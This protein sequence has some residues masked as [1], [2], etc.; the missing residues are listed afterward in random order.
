MAISVSQRISLIKGIAQ[1]LED[2]EWPM[3]DLTLTQFKLPT[4]NDFIGNKTTYVIQMVKVASD[5]ILIELAAHLGLIV[6]PTGRT[7]IDPTFW[8]T[9][10]FKL[11][12]SHLAEHRRWVGELQSELLKFGIS[13]FVAHNDIEPS[14]EWQTQIELALATCD[15]LVALLHKKFHESKWTD[16]EIG[17]VMG[18]SLPIFA[19]R[20]GQDPYGFIGRFQA[21]QG[22]DKD[23]TE[24][25]Q[26]L[27]DC[28]RKNKQTQ[29][30]MAEAL[31]RLF[32]ESRS[33]A[34]AKTRIGYLE[35][36]EVWEPSFSS[37]VTEAVKKN[38][39]IEYSFGVPARVDSLAKKWE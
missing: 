37:R 10:T 18:R 12:L 34:A 2:E 11:F 6:E 15:G 21:F 31:L 20:L 38:D 8:G 36:L 9:G 23:P 1:R 22:L 25:A 16:Q 17:F 33:F 14:T 35:L 26:E 3:V 27:F 4:S 13:A 28:F 32:E 29:K 24:I 39:Q 7:S 5:S 30:R 19:V